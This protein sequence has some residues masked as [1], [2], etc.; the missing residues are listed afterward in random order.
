LSSQALTALLWLQRSDKAEESSPCIAT[1]QGSEWHE[2]DTGHSI[3]KPTVKE[4]TK[5]GIHKGK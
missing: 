1:L 3:G 5:R 4:Q 2:K